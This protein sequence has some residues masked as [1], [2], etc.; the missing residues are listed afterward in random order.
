MIVVYIGRAPLCDIANT[1]SGSISKTVFAP[2]CDKLKKI[3]Q[4]VTWF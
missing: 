2:L 3:P 4:F 1:L